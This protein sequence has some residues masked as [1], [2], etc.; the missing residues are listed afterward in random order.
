MGTVFLGSPPSV[1]GMVFRFAQARVENDKVLV[2]GYFTATDD[3]EKEL[4][5]IMIE[6]IANI[7]SYSNKLVSNGKTLLVKSGEALILKEM[8]GYICENLDI[9][10]YCKINKNFVGNKELIYKYFG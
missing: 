9:K 8:L 5:Q 10:L 2:T 3:N 1:R 7:P 4:I 6:E